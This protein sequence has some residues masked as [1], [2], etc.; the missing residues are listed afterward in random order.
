M[1]VQFPSAG[2]DFSLR[3][4]SVQTLLRYPYTLFAIACINLCAHIKNPVAHVRVWWIRKNT[5][6]PSMRCR[7]GS[8]TMSRLAFPEESNP[9][10]PWEEPQWENVVVFLIK[11]QAYSYPQGSVKKKKKKKRH[12]L[13]ICLNCSKQSKILLWLSD[14]RTVSRQILYRKYWVDLKG[15]HAMSKQAPSNPQKKVAGLWAFCAW[16]MGGNSLFATQPFLPI[17]F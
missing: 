12:Q 13:K 16:S 14:G 8:V 15:S 4:I 9:N 11:S 17:F 5:K 2:R 1:Q 6:T 10:F 3:Q 7:L